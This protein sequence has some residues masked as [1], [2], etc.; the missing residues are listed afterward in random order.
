M[1]KLLLLA[2]SLLALDARADPGALRIAVVHEAELLPSEAKAVAAAEKRLGKRQAVTVADAGAAEVA[3]ASA[4]SGT[5]P[6]EWGGAGTVV[7]LYVLPPGGE[8]SKR[9]SRGVGSVLVFRP[10]QTEPVYAERVE[11][12]VATPLR[13]DVLERWLS[14]VVALAARAGGAR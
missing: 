7:V 1:W 8:K 3:F 9:V 11:G 2:V 13:A 14:D 12:D 5:A 4:P 6:A 10:P